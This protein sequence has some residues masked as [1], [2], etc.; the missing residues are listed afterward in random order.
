M[1]DSVVISL[2][3]RRLFSD[4]S[5]PLNRLFDNGNELFSLRYEK[6][7]YVRGRFVLVSVAESRFRRLVALLSSSKPTC[8]LGQYHLGFVVGEVAIRP[9]NKAR[10]FR[11]SGTIVKKKNNFTFFYF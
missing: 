11:M 9:A 2:K 8:D 10:S 7:F 3:K 6:N 4:T 1:P 5:T